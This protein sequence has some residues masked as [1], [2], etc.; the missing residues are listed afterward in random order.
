MN[1]ETKGR[2]VR[3]RAAKTRSRVPR[4]EGERVGTIQGVTI[5]VWGMFYR[6]N[7]SHQNDEKGSRTKWSFDAYFTNCEQF[8]F[9]LE[10]Y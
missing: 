6:I 1:K 10:E 8:D 4:N 5:C 9:T 3:R 7:P 2:E